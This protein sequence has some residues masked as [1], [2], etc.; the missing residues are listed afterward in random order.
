MK[1]GMGRKKIKLGDLLVEANAITNE[2]LYDALKKQKELGKKLGETL[3]ELGYISQELLNATLPQQL[4]IDFIELRAAK[5]DE[6]AIALFPESLARKH[7]AI[8]IGFD[9]TNGNVLRVA[10]VDPMDI[11]AMDDM[12]IV[13]NMQ[14]DP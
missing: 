4:G 11:I 9:E 12:A 7:N 6:D 1:I 3:I 13:T 5:L 10:M 14:I 8:P 2:Q